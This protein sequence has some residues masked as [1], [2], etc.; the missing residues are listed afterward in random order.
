M[1]DEDGGKS[2][3]LLIKI[4]FAFNEFRTYKSTKTR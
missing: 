3:I 4:H 2:L 1:N